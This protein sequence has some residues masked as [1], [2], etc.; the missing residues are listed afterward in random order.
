MVVLLLYAAVIGY[1]R[2]GYIFTRG[3]SP[4]DISLRL[5]YIQAHVY[6][7]YDSITTDIFYSISIV[8]GGCC[9]FWFHVAFIA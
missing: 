6:T 3:S 5:C 7:I 9:F 1:W 4:T 2:N 8:N